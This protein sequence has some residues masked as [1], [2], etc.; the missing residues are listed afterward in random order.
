MLGGARLGLVAIP[1]LLVASA[2][3]GSLVYAS[4]EENV[5]PEWL[6][7]SQW[8]LW[9][10]RL[11]EQVIKDVAAQPQAYAR[12]PG[13]RRLMLSVA[14]NWPEVFPCD[15][16][17]WIKQAS[18]GPAASLTPQGADFYRTLLRLTLPYIPVSEWSEILDDY[19][20]YVFNPD[21]ARSLPEAIAAASLR[22]ELRSYIESVREPETGNYDLSRAPMAPASCYQ[23]HSQP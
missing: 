18:P 14:E 13:G 7:P 19:P 17:N 15:P 16:P 20:P 9:M 8:D 1:A 21:A 11:G 12:T 6:Q 3:F 4:E 23:P 22:S 2:F 10:A 5:L